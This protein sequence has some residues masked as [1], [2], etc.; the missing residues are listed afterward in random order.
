[1]RVRGRL[2]KGR[3]AARTTARCHRPAAA[4]RPPPPLPRACFGTLASLQ[5]LPQLLRWDNTL[6]EGGTEEKVRRAR[7][8]SCTEWTGGRKCGG[9]R[10]HP[11]SSPPPPSPLPFPSHTLRRACARVR[12]SLSVNFR[13]MYVCVCVCGVS[14]VFGVVPRV[15][16]TA[17]LN[18]RGARHRYRAFLRGPKQEAVRTPPRR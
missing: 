7:T 2:P 10:G 12:P 17:P 3:G 16:V 13:F 6:K 4:S 8:Q 14:A 18:T 1:M 11:A 15:P 9:R 5:A